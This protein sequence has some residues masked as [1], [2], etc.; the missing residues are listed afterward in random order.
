MKTNRGIAVVEIL[1]VVA[2]IG[3]AVFSLYQLLLA[4]RSLGSREMRRTQ[5]LSLA[6]EGLEAVRNIR[7][8]GWSENIEPLVNTTTYYLTLSGSAWTLTT[9]NPGPEN[10]LFTRTI[11]FAEVN[12][13]G[14]SNI[15]PAGT[16]D[17]NTRQVT[18]T[19][20]WEERGSARTVS[21]STYL[22]NFLDT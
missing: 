21:V 5:A 3:T 1:V 11:T 20:S 2:I 10:D 22:T 17:P 8:Q 18:S 4:S 6:Q 7:D 15:S 16:A 14:N 19:V 9:A 12:R 13:D